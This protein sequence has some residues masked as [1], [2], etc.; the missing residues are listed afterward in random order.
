M[1]RTRSQ[2][3]KGALLS[4][5]HQPDATKGDT[6]KIEVPARWR[7]TSNHFEVKRRGPTTPILFKVVADDGKAVE[8][9]ITEDFARNL[10][11]WLV[12]ISK[13]KPAEFAELVNFIK[14]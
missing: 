6:K 14:A 13:T 4:N 2:P 10:A 12:V 5:N 11:A 3:G 9:G 7:D 8:V 1:A